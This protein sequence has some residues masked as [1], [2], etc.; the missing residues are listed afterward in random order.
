MDIIVLLCLYVY[1]II[2]CIAIVCIGV[3]GATAISVTLF[4]YEYVV[5]IRIYVG[6]V[7]QVLGKHYRIWGYGTPCA[8]TLGYDG[9][10][11][12]VP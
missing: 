6:M 3:I 1:C 5:L 12:S 2:V 10:D 8:S 11:W 4:S 7:L 9:I